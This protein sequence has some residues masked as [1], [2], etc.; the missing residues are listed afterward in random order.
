M[1]TSALSAES[2][3][4]LDAVTGKKILAKNE[5][6]RKGIAS[7]TK[8]MTAMIAL[9]SGDLD[10]EITVKK[11]ETLIEGSSMYLKE[12]ETFTLEELLYGL[13][14]RSGNDASL[15]ISDSVAGSKETFVE[16]MNARAKLLGLHNTSFA[17]PNGLDDENHY[18]TAYEL[19]VMSAAA[20]KNS[21]FRKIVSTKSI[22]LDGEE[23]EPRYFKNSNKLLWYSDEIIGIKTGFTKKCGRTLVSAS[24]KYGRTFIAVTLNAPNDWNDHMAMHKDGTA[25][26][27]EV[28]VYLSEYLPKSLP[29]AGGEAATVSLS[30]PNEVLIGVFPGE[31]LT[32]VPL[33]PKFIYA[34]AKK[35][36]KIGSAEIMIEGKLLATYEVTVGEAVNARAVKKGIFAKLIEKFRLFSLIYGPK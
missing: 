15:A 17:N 10:E 34:P 14:L 27:K 26:L 16:M 29:V 19:A 4:F 25:N 23:H 21:T 28:A 35:G 5:N 32:V 36:Q 1:P 12:G 22:A 7:T 18:S 31:K 30:Y 24:E 33:L 20:M 8:I 9:E 3:V 2:A 13:L 6:S 11:E